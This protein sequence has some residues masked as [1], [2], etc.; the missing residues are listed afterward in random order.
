MER[1][2]HNLDNSTETER[3]F[4]NSL[5]G[6]GSRVLL[7]K[8]S[9]IGG[10]ESEVNEGTQTQS[11]LLDP[12]EIGKQIRLENG[13]RTSKV[14]DIEFDTDC[15]RITTETS[16]YELYKLF[17]GISLESDIGD[18]SLPKD[19]DSAKLKLGSAPPLDAKA[20]ERICRVK[21]DRD[22][23]KDILIQTSGAVVHK[24]YD[25]YMVL[26]RV[27]GAHVPFYRSSSGTSG[28]N[29]GEWY[30]YFG[31]TGDWIIKG[32]VA[33]D[34]SMDYLPEITEVQA[35]L[36][37]HLI[38]PD[39]DF[40]DYRD[41][42]IKSGDTVIYSLGDEIPFANFLDYEER[43]THDDEEATRMYIKKITG[44]NPEKLKGYHPAVNDP[45]KKNDSDNWKKL[46]I[47]A[48]RKEQNQM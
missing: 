24:I 38:L 12:I 21:I 45:V 35:K 19:A 20:G 13:A 34:G 9:I 25:R 11:V 1:V 14:Q 47:E 39:V 28:K 44:Y 32:G 7:V 27:G 2:P 48:V 31:H 43:K 22:Q 6:K 10:G 29:Q 41:L 15:I 18:V 40:V 37:E 8:S 4:E 3:E 30:P 46:I 16:V 5:P 26:A 36:N 17:S 42:T 23:L 33:E